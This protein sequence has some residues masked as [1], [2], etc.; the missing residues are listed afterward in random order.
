MTCSQVH[1]CHVLCR[2]LAARLYVILVLLHIRCKLL[3]IFACNSWKALMWHRSWFHQP[4]VMCWAWLAINSCVHPVSQVELLGLPKTV[5]EGAVVKGRLQ[6]SS[7]GGSVAGLRLLTAEPDLLL[8]PSA[9]LASH[10]DPVSDPSS[11]AHAPVQPGLQARWLHSG[12]SL[13]GQKQGLA[14]SSSLR[15]ATS[16]DGASSQQ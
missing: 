5:A 13:A 16:E 6:L 7:R 4:V 12:W 9:H 10:A 15:A 14:K 2:T 3:C 11:G 1:C 8:D